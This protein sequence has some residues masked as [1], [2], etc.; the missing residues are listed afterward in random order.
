MK[1]FLI[2]LVKT[3]ELMSLGTICISLIFLVRIIKSLIEIDSTVTVHIPRFIEPQPPADKTPNRE[4]FEILHLNPSVP[5]CVDDVNTAY[6]K[7]LQLS[8]DNQAMCKKSEFQLSDL[9]A[10]KN[11]LIDFCAYA[12]Y[13]N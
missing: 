6:Y 12:A 4:Y 7:I 1:Q 5:I 8:S 2:S 13:N 11:Y 3:E 10:A 9:K